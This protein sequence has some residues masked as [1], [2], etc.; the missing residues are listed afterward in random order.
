MGDLLVMGG[1]TRLDIPAQRILDEADGKLKSAIVLGYSNSG[2][3]YF[4]SSIA[5]GADVLWLLERFKL[6]LLNVVDEQ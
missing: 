3:E 6:K 2:D 5:D 1:I 4:A